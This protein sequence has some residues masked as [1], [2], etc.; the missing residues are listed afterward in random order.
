[1]EITPKKT[2]GQ[3]FLINAGILEKIVD[4]A[5]LNKDDTI[6]EVGPGT[7]NLTRLLSEKAG[8]VIAVEKDHR[9]IEDLE[10]EFPAVKFIEGDILKLDINEL[11]RNLKLEIRNSHYKVAGNIPYYI[12]SHLLKTIFERWP[13]P[14]LMVLTIQKEV[15][16]RIVAKPPDMN[17]LALSIQ[18]YAEP[19][20]IGYI[21]KGSF[22][23]IPKV[24]SAIIKMK[25]KEGLGIKNNEK[26]LILAKKA[27]AG[28]RK[29]LKNTIGP[30]ILNKAGVKLELRPEELSLEDWLKIT[31]KV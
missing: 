3:N 11:F 14:K 12:T 28:K 19:K 16:Q 23:P 25:P 21:S 18:L 5:E 7:G 6:L 26:V 9:L 1:M 29:Q 22:R 27:F 4:A 2:L 8:R 24:D 10:K 20:I 31:S 15:A 17:L 30:E 13:K